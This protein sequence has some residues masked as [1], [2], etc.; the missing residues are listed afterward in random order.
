MDENRAVGVAPAPPSPA[1]P[2]VVNVQLRAIGGAPIL[3][4]TKF[5]A[6]GSES[7]A[8]IAAFLRAQ[9]SLGAGDSLWVSVGPG[10][11]PAPDDTLAALADA[12]GIPPA[13]AGATAAISGAGGPA[14][15]GTG[16]P[17]AGPVPAPTAPPP[18]ASRELIVSYSL[19]NAF[20]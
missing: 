2:R 10:I 17:G 4:K 20:G 6:G 1:A 19:T 12:F 16:E 14:G 11:V 7:V 3:R 9:L 5:K 18:S 15:A 8:T 13:G